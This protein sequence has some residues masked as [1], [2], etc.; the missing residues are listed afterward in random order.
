[1]EQVDCADGHSKLIK[2]EAEVCYRVELKSLGEG[3]LVHLADAFGALR[4]KRL[5]YHHG[6]VIV[7]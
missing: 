7:D 2:V 6:M 1:V 4:I 5:E 3:V